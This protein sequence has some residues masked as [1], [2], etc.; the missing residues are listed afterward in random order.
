LREKCDGGALM[1]TPW[2]LAVVPVIH[3]LKAHESNGT[4]RGSFPID[5][6]RLKGTLFV[7]V[8]R[9][10]VA[11]PFDDFPTEFSYDLTLSMTRTLAIVFGLLMVLIGAAPVFAANTG[12]LEAQLHPWRVTS[13]S[14][15]TLPCARFLNI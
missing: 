3:C 11:P 12:W 1:G 10:I 6:R 14:T 2:S 9:R 5:L 4:C 8:A 13:A 7:K 15:L